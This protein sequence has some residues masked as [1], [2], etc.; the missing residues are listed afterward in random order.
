MSTDRTEV[1][2]SYASEG[3]IAGHNLMNDCR[4]FVWT[5]EFN[6]HGFNVMLLFPVR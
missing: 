6:P 5:G 2:G 4:Y 3:E 1:K